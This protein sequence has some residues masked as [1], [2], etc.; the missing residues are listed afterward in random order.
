MKVHLLA[1]STLLAS[2]FALAKPSSEIC[3]VLPDLS[4]QV[5]AHMPQTIDRA[6]QVI[7]T[8][9]NQL[10]CDFIYMMVLDLKELDKEFAKEGFSNGTQNPELM[11]IY[12]DEMQALM[13]NQY[14]TLPLLKAFRDVNLRPIYVYQDQF[15]NHL[16]QI[17]VY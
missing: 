10:N 14:R 12:W 9:G 15:G 13:N 6:T 2:A 16:K 3:N 8:H 4:N 7:T 1:I 17:Q 11:R 5:N